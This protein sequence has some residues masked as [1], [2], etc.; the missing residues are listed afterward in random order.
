MKYKVGD[1][2]RIRNDLVVDAL[3]G[4]IHLW[5]NM[6]DFKGRVLTV[7][8][9]THENNYKVEESIYIFSDEMI[10]G[11]A[12]PIKTN[13]EHYAEALLQYINATDCDNYFDEIMICDKCPIRVIC[14]NFVG[15]NKTD[16]FIEWCKEEYK[17]QRKTIQMTLFEKSILECAVNQG[18]E[19]IARD[20]DENLLC[21]HKTRPRKA[22]CIWGSV[23]DENV[24]ELF[25]DK[26][27][28]IQ[29]T[30]EEPTYIPTLLNE[31]EVVEND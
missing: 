18:Y 3:Y 22:D 19:W 10:E 4:N 7:R 13:L 29:W 11:L 16:E 23:D 8:G 1:K 27:Q 28:F 2:V 9:Y 24:L 5:R 31:C 26:F 17:E 6:E 20:D 15:K 25:N 14:N 30:D 12:E 21:I